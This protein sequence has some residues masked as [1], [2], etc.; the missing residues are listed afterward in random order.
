MI[1]TEPAATFSE[2]DEVVL[3]TGSYQGTLGVFVRLKEDPKW[4][5]IKERDGSIRSHPVEWLAHPKGTTPVS[6]K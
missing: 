3:A 2:G 6:A 1:S 4:A 5:D